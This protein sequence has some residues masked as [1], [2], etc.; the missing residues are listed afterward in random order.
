MNLKC[1]KCQ[2][3]FAVPPEVLRSPEPRAECPSCGAR[4]RLKPRTGMLPAD[5]ASA[6]DLRLRTT[7][8]LP[9]P[10]AAAPSAGP[11]A[12]TAAPPGTPTRPHPL[13]P[14][15]VATPPLDGRLT[16][17][18][19]NPQRSASGTLADPESATV[20]ST[21]GLS[22]GRLR[23]G[24]PVFVA[25]DLVA[26]RYRIVR[27]LAQ[28]GMGEV[29]EAEDIELRQEVALK[30]VSAH[31]GGDPAAIDRF[32]R[33]IALARRVTHPNV[34]RIFD[35]GQHLLPPLPDGQQLPPLTFLTM[36]LLRG[37]TL[38]QLLRRRGRLGVDEALPLIEQMAAALDAAHRAMIVHRD[39]KS[40]NV[41]LVDDATLGGKRAVVTDFGVARGADSSDRFAAQVT[42]LGIV[43][44]PAYMAPEQVE[45]KEITAA[46]DL[47]ALGIVIYEMVTGKLPFESPN[48]L[49]TAVKRLKEAPPPPHVLVPDLPAYWEKAILRCLEREP[50][51]RFATAGEL[52]EALRKPVRGPRPAES[53]AAELKPPP[54][55]LPLP[56]PPR[57]AAAPMPR[58]SKLALVLLVVVLLSAGLFAFNVLKGKKGSGKVE[59][60]RSV[61]VFGLKNL[62]Q[63]D[64]AAWI[65]TAVAEMLSN[66]LGRGDSLRT[67][68]GQEVTEAR[69]ELDLKELVEP[70]GA[71]LD[72]VRSRLGCD[73]VV[74]GSYL[75][76]PGGAGDQ[77]RIDLRLLDAAA[78]KPL[79]S[80]SEQGS[81]T[82]LIPIVGKLGENLRQSLGSKTSSEEADAGLPKNAEAARLY[83]EALDALRAAQPLAAR[84]LLERAV[85]AEGDNP[86]IHSALASVWSALG[87]GGKEADEARRAFE[88]SSRLPR[89]EK[90]LIEGRLREAEGNPAAARDLYRTL[91]EA[92]PDNLEYG[93][94]LIAAER[95]AGS[96]KAALEMVDALRRLPPQLADDIRIDLAEAEAAAQSGLFE[97]QLIAAERAVGKAR[98]QGARLQLARGL[99]Q[100]AQSQRVL[101]KG[102]SVATA[103]EALALFEELGHPV[104][105]AQATSVYGTSL[106]AAGKLDEAATAAEA[107]AALYRQVG[108]QGGLAASLNNLAIAKKRQGDLDRVEA[109]YG[110]TEQIYRQTGD[111]RGLA[112]AVNN[113]AVLEV[114]RD[115][116]AEARKMFESSRPAWEEIAGKVGGA[117]STFNLAQVLRLEGQLEEARKLH[118]EALDARRAAGIKP[119]YAASL[120]Q[121]AGLLLEAGQPA[122]AEPLLTEAHKVATEVGERSLLAAVLSQEGEL[123]LLR[124]DF[125]GAREAL[126]QALD[127]RL[128]GQEALL[129]PGCKLALARLS[130]AEG[131]PVEA[132]QLAREALEAADRDGRPAE[133]TRAAA[134]LALALLA[135]GENDEA[136]RLIADRNT[137]A[138]TSEQPYLRLH[139]GLAEASLLAERDAKAALPRLTELG[140]EAR[141]LLYLPLALEIDLAWAKAAAR[142]GRAGEADT[143]R[144]AAAAEAQ[145]KGLTLLQAQLEGKAPSSP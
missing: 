92:Y 117:L 34:C 73:Y 137:A 41:F 13:P 58:S 33:E 135:D 61:A 132:T 47:Y 100:V 5:V 35:L 112:L 67:I 107:A 141:R 29:Y 123:K 64:D 40:E 120:T 57:P 7:P 59:L 145:N 97:R 65:S 109:L 119:D 66:E 42:G 118:Q 71:E 15:P 94:S 18:L 89:E 110:E 54:A 80:F 108:D 72:K 14:R 6:G 8:S 26:Q 69:Q 76:L 50:G 70:S 128:A 25:G 77:L 144:Q 53:K 106:L 142:A 36:E 22:S 121:L 30:T 125:K 115:H 90:L 48:P 78:G 103:R 37:E 2:T 88:L 139:F 17:P 52:V 38:S 19:P 39:F 82:E 83:A 85:A 31:I 3:E 24:G 44:T 32:K 134:L 81:L 131:V 140:T 122:A 74:S 21:G 9:L 87:Y 104:G 105:K 45:N 95:G 127:L 1:G 79:G 49:T 28:G 102:D 91:Y 75:S 129:V 4:Y 51:D 20:V 63:R 138:S 46:A 126:Q 116:L 84:P 113:Q 143:R 98:Q 68:S 60:R 62:T 27:F 130:L 11:P 114:E 43:G 12:A 101:G 136:R 86:L 124:R 96:P 93:L 99:L 55:P 111:R 23:L 56:A 10:P 16:T 133:A